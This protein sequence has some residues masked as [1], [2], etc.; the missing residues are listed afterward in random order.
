MEALLALVIWLN[1]GSWINPVPS[2][3]PAPSPGATEWATTQDLLP[4]M[5]PPTGP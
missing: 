5:P 4:G 2:A 3:S 1:L